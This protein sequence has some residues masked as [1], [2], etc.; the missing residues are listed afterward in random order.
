MV[1]CQ[2][3]T[4]SVFHMAACFD[5]LEPVDI[6]QGQGSLGDSGT[7]RLAILSP[8]SFAHGAGAAVRWHHEFGLDQFARGVRGVDRVHGI[9][10]TSKKTFFTDIEGEA[11]GR[12]WR[13]RT[14]ASTAR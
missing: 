5:D 14:T 2:C 6:A 7:G 10:L 11:I 1:T 9:V 13:T 12:V 4:L 8:S 3:A